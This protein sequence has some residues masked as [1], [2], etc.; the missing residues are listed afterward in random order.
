MMT[1]RADTLFSITTHSVV[2]WGFGYVDTDSCVW[3]LAGIMTIYAIGFFMDNFKIVQIS[4]AED[5]A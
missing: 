5:K 3:V 2:G 1:Q 4:K